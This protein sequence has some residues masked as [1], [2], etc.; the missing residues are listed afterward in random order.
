MEVLTHEEIGQISSV[1]E[2]TD[3]ERTT[4]KCTA[5]PEHLRDLYSRRSV[6]LNTVEREKAK[7]SFLT[8]YADLF[9]KPDIDIGQTDLV[10]HALDTG[11]QRPR[12][13]PFAER[14]AAAE[15]LKTLLDNLMLLR[16]GG[17]VGWGWSAVCQDMV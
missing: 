12:R 9:S 1:C 7:F 2:Q 14:Q 4:D 11:G 3:S 13:F 17:G 5:V 16:G 8:W 6:N 15:A 10:E